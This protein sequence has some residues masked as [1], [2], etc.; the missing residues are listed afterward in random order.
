MIR[1]LSRSRDVLGS[2]AAILVLLVAS[3]FA[4][5][6]SSAAVPAPP[7]CTVPPCLTVC[8]A[9]DRPFSVVVRDIVGLPIPGSTVQLFLANCPDA[10]VALCADC[11]QAPGYD[12]GTRTFTRISDAS[13]TATFQ[14]CGSVYCPT[15]SSDWVQVR[16]D[17]VLLRTCRFVTTDPDG[18][19]DVDA[20]DVALVVGAAGGPPAHY[21]Q[22]CDAIVNATDADIVRTHLGHSCPGVVPAG[23]RTWGRIKS[24]Y[25]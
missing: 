20:S 1:L 7:L 3:L 19:L 24:T 16:A 15:A 10:V 6:T 17:G 23:A 8:P 2:S 12:A 9:G 13:G 18:D 5:A 22:N 25:R 14:I 21:D 11:A 4:P